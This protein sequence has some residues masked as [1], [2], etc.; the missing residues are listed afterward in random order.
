MSRR[1]TATSTTSV[2]AAASRPTTRWSKYTSSERNG[3]RRSISKESTCGEVLLGG[4]G[5]RGAPHQRL[6]L[7]E[8]QARAPSRLAGALQ[9]LPHGAARLLRIRRDGNA[10][11]RRAGRLRLHEDQLVGLHGD[12]GTRVAPPSAAKRSGTICASSPVHQRQNASSFWRQA[13]ARAAGPG[14]GDEAIIAAPAQPAAAGSTAPAVD[15]RHEMNVTALRGTGRSNAT[16]S[17]T[18]SVPS[19]SRA[20]ERMVA[21][22]LEPEAMPPACG[23]AGGGSPW[24]RRLVAVGDVA[25][26]D[27]RREPG[28]GEQ[29]LA[30]RDLRVHAGLA[31]EHRDRR[32]EAAIQVRT[33]AEHEL[34]FLDR[35]EGGI[36]GFVG[37][38][39]VPVVGLFGAVGPLER[40]G[41]APVEDRIE[42]P[43][44]VLRRSGPT[45]S[46]ARAAAARRRY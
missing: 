29:H 28:N 10:V 35:L 43:G 38:T 19:S 5:H 2:A 30:A 23:R 20:S 24:R 26:D 46:T 44:G 9:H 11:L 14:T 1:A 41:I 40:V 12:L 37:E 18:K 22:M 6:V 42:E 25:I 33:H 15:S 34:Q 32:G 8:H 17:R 31:R 36:G 3:V 13:G 4:S 27:L 16:A 39:G 7:R 21:T 45:R